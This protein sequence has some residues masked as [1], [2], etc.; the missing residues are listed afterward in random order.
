MP[1]TSGRCQ[2]EKF[3]S[4]EFSFEKFS[5]EEPKC[6]PTKLNLTFAFKI[7]KRESLASPEISILG[8]IHEPPSS[9]GNSSSTGFRTGIQ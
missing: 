3:S 2:F 4:E 6:L 1:S 8:I 9:W 5:F 7:H